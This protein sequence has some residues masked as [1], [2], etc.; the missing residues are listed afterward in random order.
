MGKLVKTLTGGPAVQ[1]DNS[2]VEMA[3]KAQADALA[4]ANNLAANYRADL[5]NNNIAN[6]VA[7]GSADAVGSVA[8][9][10][11]KKPGSGLSSVLGIS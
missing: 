8:D 1:V 2:G 10:I 11:K 7:G 3:A 5:T 9:I 6:V 4:A